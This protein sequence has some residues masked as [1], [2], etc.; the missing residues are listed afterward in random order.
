MRLTV[1]NPP[2]W[3]VKLTEGRI[4]LDFIIALIPAVIFALIMY[5]MHAARVIVLAMSTAVISEILIRKLFKKPQAFT[6]GSAF[7]IGLLFALIL[8]PSVPFWL[9]I[10]GA[11]LCIFI[12]KEL[13]GGLGSP[14]L[15]PVLVGWTILQI[16][17]PGHL[18]INLAAA[19]YDLKFDFR[20]PLAMLKTG[21]IEAI[22]DYSFI[23]LVLGKQTA[24]LGASAIILIFIGGVYLLVRRR[25]HWEIPLSFAVG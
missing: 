3:H 7:L 16:S 23:D 6:D 15:N 13:F 21:G 24:G 11:F 22:S 5:G 18:N 4:H 25:I 8:P 20:Y 12:G 14:P 17:W 19:I 1:S 9:V 2:H 10:V